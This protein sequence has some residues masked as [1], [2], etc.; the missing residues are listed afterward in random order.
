MKSS[1]ISEA[2]LKAEVLSEL[3]RQ[4]VISKAS[5]IANEFRVGNASLRADLAI[6]TDEFIGIE[7]KSELDSLR[8][9]ESQ[10]QLYLAY[11]DRV[12][13]VLASRHLK[14][15]DRRLLVGAE[16]WEVTS[17]GKFG[18]LNSLLGVH[19][20]KKPF[21]DLMT[22]QERKR[23][24][25]PISSDE[26]FETQPPTLSERKMFELAFRRRFERTSAAFW[27]AVS[28]REIR[29]DDLAHLSRFHGSRRERLK[30]TEAQSVLWM[31]WQQK[32]QAIF[33]D[34]TIS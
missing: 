23:Y 7:I 13:V 6:F 12:I 3:R 27:K 24:N 5:T 31:D 10:T 29:P 8:R 1:K 34:P 4:S 22:Q 18:V 9:L 11:F 14:N 2:K 20:Q 17:D 21:F 16:I 33:A 25:K 30:W 15:V 19:Q 32:A 26:L 28:R